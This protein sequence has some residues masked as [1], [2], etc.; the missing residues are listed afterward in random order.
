MTTQRWPMPGPRL[1]SRVWRQLGDVLV[2]ARASDAAMDARIRVAWHDGSAEAWQALAHEMSATAE[3]IEGRA[4]TLQWHVLTLA[5]DALE[6][7]GGAVFVMDAEGTPR[8]H[9]TPQSDVVEAAI[10]LRGKA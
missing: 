3:V 1:P 7:A 10:L 5:C 8:V 9:Q 6:L 4:D 2:E